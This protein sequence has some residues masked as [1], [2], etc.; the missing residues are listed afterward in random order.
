MI[1]PPHILSA[2]ES[3]PL[4]PDPGRSPSRNAKRKRLQ[5]ACDVCDSAEMPNRRCTNCIMFKTECTHEWLTGPPPASFSPTPQEH[6]SRILSTSTVY[7]TPS[8]PHEVLIEIA[9]Y[10]QSLEQK[11]AALQT[12]APT[13]PSSRRGSPLVPSR[14]YSPSSPGDLVDHNDLIDTRPEPLGYARSKSVYEVIDCMGETSGAFSGRRPEFW[15]T[16]PWETFVGEPQPQFFPENDL[17]SNLVTLYFEEIN[18]LLGLLHFRSFRQLVTEGLHLRDPHFGGVVLVV[19]ALASRYSDDPRV[20][21]DGVDNDEHSCGWKWFQ[22]VRPLCASMSPKPSLHQLQLI[23]LC[24]LFLADI[25]PKADDSWTLAGL[26]VRLAQGAGVHRRSGYIGLQPLEAELYKR[27]FWTLVISDTLMGAFR[28]K[29]QR[30]QGAELDVDLPVD[31]DDEYLR[32]PTAMQP[33]GHPASSAFML[34]WYSP[35]VY[36]SRVYLLIYTSIMLGEL[37]YSKGAA[38]ELESALNKWAAEIPAHLR[39]NPDQEN[40]VFLEQSATLGY[41]LRLELTPVAAQILIHR[42]FI[43]PPRHE[44][45]SQTDFPSLVSCANAARSFGHILDVQTRRG[46]GPLRHPYVM[47]TLFDCVVVLIMNA[48]VV[49]GGSR[50]QAAER[51]DCAAADIQHCMRVL[52]LHERRWRLAGQLCDIISRMLDIGKQTAGR[53]RPREVEGVSLAAS[54]LLDDFLDAF[55]GPILGPSRP[56]SVTQQM[57]TLERAFQEPEN[58]FSLPPSGHNDEIGPQLMF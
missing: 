22:Q 55:E 48:W 27:A 36:P 29:P 44:P 10:A 53:K 17:L 5:G 23:C 42:I 56:V 4:H 25:M 15:S 41:F 51:Y 16:Q 38:A 3:M 31:W 18:P 47:Y 30:I 46:R 33:S 35:V 7:I 2:P 57:F 43:P 50:N 54:D 32:R 40:R 12:P 26:G 11:L 21:I 8:D 19:C 13:P 14:G 45:Q 34:L 28:G 24:V 49:V 39:W 20:F 9:Q 52:R 6:V 37:E 1:H 58:L